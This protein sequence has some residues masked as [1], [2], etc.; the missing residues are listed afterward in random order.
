[1]GVSLAD[2]DG[3]AF[4]GLRSYPENY[5]V[6]RANEHAKA[7]ADQRRLS[8]QKLLTEKPKEI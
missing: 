3:K 2:G 7:L 6:Q 4:W 5:D 8:R 1:M